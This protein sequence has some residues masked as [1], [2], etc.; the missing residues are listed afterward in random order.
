MVSQ[1]IEGGNRKSGSWDVGDVKSE[2]GVGGVVGKEAGAPSS[3]LVSV[4]WT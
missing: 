2:V 4:I 3:D 1:K